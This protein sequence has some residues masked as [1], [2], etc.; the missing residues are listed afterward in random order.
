MLVTAVVLLFDVLVTVVLL[1]SLVIV[2]DTPQQERFQVL[3]RVACEPSLVT[4]TLSAGTKK[5]I[6]WAQP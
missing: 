1:L 3:F 5:S 6:A 2:E 4:T